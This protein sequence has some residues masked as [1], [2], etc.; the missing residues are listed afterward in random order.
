MSTRTVPLPEPLAGIAIAIH[1]ALLA[2]VHAQSAAV[3]MLTGCEPPAAGT[4]I[5]S[6]ATTALHPLPCDTVNV[7]PP[8]V[9]VPLRAAP[10]FGDAVNCT[11]P[12][13]LPVAPDVTLIHPAF[14]TAVHAHEGLVLTANEV[15][16]PSAGTVCDVGEMENAHPLA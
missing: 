13:P 1:G 10:E 12:G 3:E 7:W 2:A 9:I 6:G 11:V 16:P 5:V 14:A 8:A 4:G 15:A